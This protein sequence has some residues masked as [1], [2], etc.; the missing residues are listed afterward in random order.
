MREQRFQIRMARE[1]AGKLKWAFLMAASLFAA[2]AALDAVLDPDV[3]PRNLPVRGAAV[4]AF[5]ALHLL[6]RGTPS[7]RRGKRLLILGIA[8]GSLAA[9]W[10]TVGM[11]FGELVA[12][13]TLLLMLGVMSALSTTLRSA[14]SGYGILVVCTDAMGLALRA[15]PFYLFVVNVFVFS[16][17]LAGALLAAV[18]ERADRR[19]FGLELELETLAQRDSMTGLH[20]RRSFLQQAEQ[21]VTRASRYGRPMSLLVLDI[22]R[23]K[24]I[25]DTYGH[26]VGDEVIRAL[27]RAAL[28]ALRSVDV[29]GRMGGEEFAAVLPETDAAGA[30]LTGER[31]RHA[32]SQAAVT[33]G[34]VQVRFTISVGVTAWRAGESL[35][36]VLAR[37]DE[38]LYAAKNGGRNRVCAAAVAA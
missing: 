20:N 8:T 7:P 4:A 3:V 26:P 13:G 17:V 32:V 21:E 10:L 28:G 6:A 24:A 14:L 11:Q 30:S 9:T 35:E 34:E 25:N 27:A 1:L 12:V 38:A 19:A 36:A 33:C 29:L 2:F 15:P 37:A 22:D 5:L 31:L 18:T 16:G 23:F